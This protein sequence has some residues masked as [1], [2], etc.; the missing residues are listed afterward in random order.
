MKKTTKH[1][2]KE[3]T[4]PIVQ[5]LRII[6]SAGIIFL[7]LQFYQ[8]NI[9]IGVIVYMLIYIIVSLIIEQIIKFRNQKSNHI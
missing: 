4:K 8:P 3:K 7:L 2:K 6:I 1:R 9:F 5:F